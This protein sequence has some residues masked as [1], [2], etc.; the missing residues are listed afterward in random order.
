MYVGRP[1][2]LI[3][4]HIHIYMYTH[5]HTN[6]YYRRRLKEGY[7]MTSTKNGIVTLAAQ[8]TME[9]NMHIIQC[10]YVYIFNEIMLLS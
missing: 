4:T 8:L 9:V 3:C 7:R 5:T 6:T 10:V 1:S 2:L